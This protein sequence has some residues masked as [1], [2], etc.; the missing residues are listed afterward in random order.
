MNQHKERLIQQKESVNQQKE[1]SNRQKD[2]GINI[3]TR[4]TTGYV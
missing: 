2:G 3:R 1:S 4:F